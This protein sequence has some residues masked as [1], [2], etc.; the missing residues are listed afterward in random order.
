MSHKAPALAPMACKCI[1]IQFQT[2]QLH[3]LTC[4]NASMPH[5]F[6]PHATPTQRLLLF[7]MGLLY[8][9]GR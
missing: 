4:P 9:V 6:Q 3:K 8:I 2:Q 5:Q 7:D 1:Y